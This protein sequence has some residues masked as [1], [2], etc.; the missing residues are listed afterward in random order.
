M[1]AFV[2]LGF[3]SAALVAAQGTITS[4]PSP[5]EISKAKRQAS[6]PLPLTEYTFS[7]SDVPYQVNPYP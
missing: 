5:T 3:A 4:A 1:L 7:Y 2:S 6:S